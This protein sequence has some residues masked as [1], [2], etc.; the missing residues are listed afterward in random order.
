[1]NRPG[2]LV[3]VLAVA[4]LLV[5]AVALVRGSGVEDAATTAALTTTTH[6]EAVVALSTPLEDINR[7]PPTTVAGVVSTTAKIGKSI[8]GAP[9]GAE[10]PGAATSLGP[11]TPCAT[12]VT[13]TAGTGGVS[14]LS[15]R[16]S[17]SAPVPLTTVPE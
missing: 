13:A 5:S 14:T 8:G 16:P 11:R 1:M 10:A 9:G 4:I 2:F 7:T 3:L 6:T 17:L 12:D 15:S